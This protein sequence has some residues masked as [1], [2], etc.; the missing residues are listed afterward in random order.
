MYVATR[1]QFIVCLLLQFTRIESD[2][3][4]ASAKLH[5]EFAQAS[6]VTFVSSRTRSS[7]QRRFP[8]QGSSNPMDI[9][10]RIRRLSKELPDLQDECEEVFAAKQVRVINTMFTADE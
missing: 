2:L 3:N 9:L 10:T 5:S 4:W 1:Q 8:C 6:E 7:R